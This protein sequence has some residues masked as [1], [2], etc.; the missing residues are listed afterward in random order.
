M[1]KK[2]SLV[3]H[4]QPGIRPVKKDERQHMSFHIPAEL[5]KAIKVAAA[6][7]GMSMTK[8]VVDE[9]SKKYL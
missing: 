6:Q 2:L 1:A 5:H 4:D 9:L 7:R 3:F 8:L